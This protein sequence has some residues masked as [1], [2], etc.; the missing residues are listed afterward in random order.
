M[1][2]KAGCRVEVQ[3]FSDEAVFHQKVQDAQYKLPLRMIQEYRKWDPLPAFLA[4]MA[5]K[6]PLSRQTP[7]RFGPRH[8]GQSSAHMSMGCNRDKAIAIVQSALE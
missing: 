7:S 4:G 5:S 2:M 6:M 1:R 3:K 8:C